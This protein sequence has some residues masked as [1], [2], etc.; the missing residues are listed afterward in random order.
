MQPQ[1]DG[2]PWG[3]SGANSASVQCFVPV[4]SQT[5]ERVGEAGLSCKRSADRPVCPSVGPHIFSERL[6][7]T[8]HP[9]K[10]GCFPPGSLAPDKRSELRGVASRAAFICVWSALVNLSWK[11]WMESP[12]ATS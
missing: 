10:R 4:P 7:T 12:S 2:G 5:A 8:Q 11:E 6:D 3:A 1:Q 9:G